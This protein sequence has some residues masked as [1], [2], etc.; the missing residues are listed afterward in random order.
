MAKL[1]R[2]RWNLFKEYA[3]REEEE[4]CVTPY[5]LEGTCIEFVKCQLILGLLECA[6]D[7]AL[8]YAHQSICSAGKF[9][10]PVCCPHKEAERVRTDLCQSTTDPDTATD[11]PPSPTSSD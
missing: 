5:G 3:T 11:I 2:I 4:T 10:A 9:H 1:T 6:T 8:D 7:E